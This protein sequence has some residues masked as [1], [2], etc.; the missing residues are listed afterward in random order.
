ML[1]ARGGGIWRARRALRV[2]ASKRH[3]E[4]GRFHSKNELGTARLVLTSPLTI[5]R[6]IFTAA[7]RVGDGSL[8]HRVL[9]RRMS[10]NEPVSA[11]SRTSLSRSHT[12][13]ENCRAE[14]GGR[15]TPFLNK[16]SRNLQSETQPTCPKPREY[17]RFS[18]A[19]HVRNRDRS[20]W[21]PW[22]D[23]NLSVSISNR[24]A[25]RLTR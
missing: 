22:K 7:S 12:D 18:D 24:S 2:R 20:G 9:I 16:N 3:I 25:R 21:L 17:R 15:K 6:R 1:F 14:T 13:I 23:S 10:S 11:R 8:S 4:G 19:G 5:G